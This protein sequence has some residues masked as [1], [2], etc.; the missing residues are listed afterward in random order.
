MERIEIKPRSSSF[1]FYKLLLALYPS[2]YTEMHGAEMLQNFLD[3]ERDS[4]STLTLW[5][6]I[7]KDLFT[8]L[9]Y[10]HMTL[11]SSRAALLAFVLFLPFLLMV[12]LTILYNAITHSPGTDPIAN[13]V[14]TQTSLAYAFIFILPAIGVLAV[15][16]DMAMDLIRERAWNPLRAAFFRNHLLSVGM[17][18]FGILILLFIPFHDA[19]PCFVQG[20]FKDG[21][22]NIGPLIQVCANA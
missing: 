22:G 14:A 11:K 20:V 8:S 6:R 4:S 7:S 3:L 1:G 13:F 17:F 18:C 19:V 10:Q 9:I 21:I 5:S 15:F 12:A 2:A 16:A